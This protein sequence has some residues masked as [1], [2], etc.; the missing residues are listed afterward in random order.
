[1]SIK[2]FYTKTVSCAIPPDSTLG[3]LLFLIYINDLKNA[4]DKCIV[5]HFADDTN[6][7]F[8]NKCPSEV[9]CVMNNELK[10]LTGWL[11]ANKLP[12]SKSK[13]NLL[14]FR[15]RRKLNITVSNTK[16]SNLILTP[17]KTVTYLDTEMNETFNIF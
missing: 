9:S 7:L 15:P 13:M 1:M 3:P 5:H 14:T 17:E 4:L 6:L 10:L 11:R 2:G 8:G 16:L 12:L